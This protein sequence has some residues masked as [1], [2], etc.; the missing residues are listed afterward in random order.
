MFFL[1][2]F[3]ED[4]KRDWEAAGEEL[5]VAERKQRDRERRRRDAGDPAKPPAAVSE[6]D[7]KLLEAAADE[8]EKITAAR[9]KIAAER[10]QAQTERDQ[11]QA[12]YDKLAAELAENKDI[13]SVMA[14]DA[15]Q[16]QAERDQLAEVLKLPGL[17]TLLAKQYFPD[18]HSKATEDEKRQLDG[19]AQKI[20]A[21]YDLIKRDTKAKKNDEAA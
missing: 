15:E 16:L 18:T 1:S 6:E 11:L 4:F 14:D 13:L 19:F 5:G 21:A 9:D 8:I 3:V 12:E 20:N 7:K 10:D 17:K 2:K